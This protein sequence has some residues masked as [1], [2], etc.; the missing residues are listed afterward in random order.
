MVKFPEAVCGLGSGIFIAGPAVTCDA[1]LGAGAIKTEG[2]GTGDR[3]PGFEDA[4]HRPRDRIYNRNECGI[5]LDTEADRATL[6]E[7]VGDADVFTR[8]FRP[9]RESSRRTDGG[10]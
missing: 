10:F 5:S 4:I 6:L 2:P 7:L 1:D 3:L 9:A 8:N